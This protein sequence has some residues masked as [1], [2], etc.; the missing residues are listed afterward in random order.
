MGNLGAL[1]VTLS[2]TWL[3]NDVKP[4][5]QRSAFDRVFNAL[6]PTGSAIATG[7]VDKIK[8]F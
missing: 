4:T 2:R 7:T 6:N 1:G 3:L 5:A 8:K